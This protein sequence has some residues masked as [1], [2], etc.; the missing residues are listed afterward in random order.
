MPALARSQ[1]V[2]VYVN[3]T[4]FAPEPVVYTSTDSTNGKVKATYPNH[5]NALAYEVNFYYGKRSGLV[6]IFYPGTDQLM[7][8]LVYNN[9]KLN[10]ETNWYDKQGKLVIKGFYADNVKEGFWVYRNY[11]LM[12]EYRKGLKNGTWKYDLP[13]G[14]KGRLKFKKGVLQRN[15]KGST[16]IP[17][18][19]R[20]LLMDG[21]T[22]L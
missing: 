19:P 8:T 3:D 10:G 18:I 7:R 2:S 11:G 14:R 6:R 21:V 9:G 12:G 1:T 5:G 15:K 17:G 4:T 20:S 22:K 16:P 13:G